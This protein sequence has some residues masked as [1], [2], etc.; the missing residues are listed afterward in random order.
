MVGAEE[1]KGFE[2]VALGELVDYKT[3]EPGIVR[4]A[5]ETIKRNPNLRAFLFECTELSAYSD[6]VRQATGLPVFDIITSSDFVINSF[7]YFI[8]FCN[9]FTYGKC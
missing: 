4:L 1:V 7:R 2:A 5:K 8:L 3:V 6:A 9:I